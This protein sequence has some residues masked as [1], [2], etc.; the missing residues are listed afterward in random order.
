MLL[1]PERCLLMKGI[2]PQKLV[3]LKTGELFVQSSY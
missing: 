1:I 2:Y 3:E